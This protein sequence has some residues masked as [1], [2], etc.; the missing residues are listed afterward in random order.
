MLLSIVLSSCVGIATN[1]HENIQPKIKPDQTLKVDYQLRVVLGDGSEA[2]WFRAEI[3]DIV[4]NELSAYGFNLTPD[5][6]NTLY[7]QYE[8]DSNLTPLR[9]IWL[10]ASF[11]TAHL[12][13]FW[14]EGEY[15]MRSVQPAN[16]ENANNI[17]ITVSEKMRTIYWTPFLL[18]L[19]FKSPISESKKIHRN[20][21]RAFAQAYG[22]AITQ[23]Q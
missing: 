8:I 12:L 19:P 2:D 21:S 6:D 1:S 20:L 4:T 15:R 22:L 16:K 13:P 7:I 5:A 14:Y 17:G 23:Q 10:I 9:S 11:G 3:Q 18:A